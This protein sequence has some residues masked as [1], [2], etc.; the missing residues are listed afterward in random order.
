MEQHNIS[1]VNLG[2]FI[3][4]NK[5]VS[6]LPHFSQNYYYKMPFII[7]TFLRNLAFEMFFQDKQKTWQR[8]TDHIHNIKII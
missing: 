5:K 3:G 8:N 2:S 6:E 7:Y 4:Y 1:S